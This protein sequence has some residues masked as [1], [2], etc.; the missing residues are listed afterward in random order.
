MGAHL[1]L[2]HP[3]MIEVH[4]SEEPLKFDD[5]DEVCHKSYSNTRQLS[6][7]QIQEPVIRPSPAGLFSLLALQHHA[8]GLHLL[9][10]RESQ[11]GFSLQSL[12]Q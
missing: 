8:V 11:Q 5:L 4:G 9:V 10:W 1:K 2:G 3:L 7:W 12:E 6:A